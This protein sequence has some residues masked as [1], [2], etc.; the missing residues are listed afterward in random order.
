[1][2]HLLDKYQQKELRVSKAKPMGVLLV[3]R[4]HV[5][6]MHG[7]YRY[8]TDFITFLTTRVMH[9]CVHACAPCRAPL[10]PSR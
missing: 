8:W 9:A 7:L 10:L 2:L 1:M 6:P 5:W 3:R 4:A